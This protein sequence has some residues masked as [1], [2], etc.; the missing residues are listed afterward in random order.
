MR[1]VNSKQKNV[2]FVRVN[3]PITIDKRNAWGDDPTN[4][5]LGPNGAY[6]KMKNPTLVS[7]LVQPNADNTAPIGWVPG[8]GPGLFSKESIWVEDE[9]LS[10]GTTKFVQTLD[11]P[12]NYTIKAPS[13]VVYNGNSAGPN[14]N[15]SWI[16]T[17]AA[18]VEN[19]EYSATASV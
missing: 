8:D 2:A 4:M 14:F 10:A 16:Q 18:L 19:Y 6:L 3:D 17:V 5:Q 9:V 13:V 12:I 11:G 1:F 15:D 7:H